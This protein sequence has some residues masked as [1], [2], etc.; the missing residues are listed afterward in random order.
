MVAPK[1]NLHHYLGHHYLCFK[2]IIF[3]KYF[4]EKIFFLNPPSILLERMKNEQFVSSNQQSST[5][6]LPKRFTNVY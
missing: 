2:S 4:I 3:L 5:E 1:G 6:M